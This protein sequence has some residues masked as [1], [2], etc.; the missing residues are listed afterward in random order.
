MGFQNKCKD[1]MLTWSQHWLSWQS[2]FPQKE[3]EIWTVKSRAALNRC[4]NIE[5]LY[6]KCKCKIC[7]R[8]KLCLSVCLGKFERVI[9]VVR[10]DLFSEAW[11]SIKGRLKFHMKLDK[12]PKACKMQQRH[13]RMPCVISNEAITHIDWCVYSLHFLSVKLL[14]PH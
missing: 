6:S 7:V 5:M 8:L 11:G 3:T 12:K 4:W 10:S 13:R 2:L 1:F 14:N 9:W